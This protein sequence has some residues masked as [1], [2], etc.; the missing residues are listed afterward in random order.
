MAHAARTQQANGDIILTLPHLGLIESKD[1]YLGETIRTIQNA[2]NQHGITVGVDPMPASTFPPPTAPTSLEV[3]AQN[4]FFDCIIT[5]A[6][7]QRGVLYFLDWST[8]AN[9][10]APRTISLGPARTEYK[11]LGNQTLYWRAYSQYQGSNISGYTYFG[12][13]AAPTPVV[14]GGSSG[15]APM[16]S[17][18]TG[19][20]ASTGANPFPPVGG[21][22]GPLGGGTG[23]R[24]TIGPRNVL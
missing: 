24:T 6:N 16:A 13:Q 10:A 17:S 12:T 19:A 20:G 9:F 1:V 8:T 22:Y 15:P 21:G 3:T 23:S 7:P 4:G 5:D 14:G 18:G 11:Q 2:I